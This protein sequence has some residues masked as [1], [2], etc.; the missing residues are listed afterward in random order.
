MD[1]TRRIQSKE[2]LM[3]VDGQKHIISGF[4]SIRPLWQIL[5]CTHI[6]IIYIYTYVYIHILYSHLLLGRHYIAGEG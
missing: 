3:M 1:L 5:T 4:H 2:R 6:C